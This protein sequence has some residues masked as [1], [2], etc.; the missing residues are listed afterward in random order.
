MSFLPEDYSVPASG[1]KY[2]KP[3][4]GLNRVRILSS[5]ILGTQ[6]WITEEGGKKRP[7]RVHMGERLPAEAK[8][9]KHFWA[10]LAYNHEASECQVWE[11]TQGTIQDALTNLA[12]NPAWGHPSGY[13]IAI[14]R[15]GQ[16][17]DTEYSVMPEPKSELPESLRNEVA[18]MRQQ[19]NLEALFD[20]GDPFGGDV[21][22]DGDE[23]P[24]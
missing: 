13:D 2:F 22:T 1:G 20:G 5:P 6:G 12:K 10:L 7:V 9:A 18:A 21:S 23:M 17:L 11:I 24:F 8:D 4:P 3:Q 14:T 16:G 19:V 15:K